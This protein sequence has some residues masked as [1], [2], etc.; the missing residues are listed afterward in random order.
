MSGKKFGI[1]GTG[2]PLTNFVQ[3]MS[4]PRSCHHQLRD[5]LEVKRREV[6][7]VKEGH[8]SED[9]EEGVGSGDVRYDM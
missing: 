3:G 9:V 8:K 5:Q 6:P 2:E 4:R 1:I 7:E